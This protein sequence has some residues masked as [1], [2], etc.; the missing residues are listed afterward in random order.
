MRLWFGNFKNARLFPLVH[1][2]CRK[3]CQLEAP[4]PEIVLEWQSREKATAWECCVRCHLSGLAEA[5]WWFSWPCCSHTHIPASAGRIHC[6][7]I[8]KKSNLKEARRALIHGLI[9]FS[10]VSGLWRGGAL[11]HEC[12]LSKLLAPGWLRN[13][14]GEEGSG[15]RVIL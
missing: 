13:R 4:K 14:N 15:T 10:E 6:D 3:G 9:G 12:G 1:K 8:L 2:R 7:K 5:T 11:W